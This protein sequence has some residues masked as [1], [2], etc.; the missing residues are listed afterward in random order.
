M[1]R[2]A[3]VT[4]LARCCDRPLRSAGHD[5]RVSDPEDSFEY[6]YLDPT[7]VV[8]TW[9]TSTKVRRGRNELTVDFLHRA[10]EHSRP[11]LVARTLVAHVVAV[12]L[13]DQLDEAWR[14][15]YEWSMPR[16]PQDE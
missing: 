4:V 8:G 14:D 12:E 15:Y 10:P 9:A 16:E 1:A 13:R 5:V 11:F 3:I 7:V 2:P 6:L